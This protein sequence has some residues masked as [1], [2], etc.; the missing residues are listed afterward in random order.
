MVLSR[1][2]ATSGAW[3]RSMPCEA[4]TVCARQLPVDAEVTPDRVVLRAHLPGFTPEQ[5]EVRATQRAVVISTHRTAEESTPGQ[6][7][8]H[9]VYHGN[10]YRRL[11]LPWPVRPE[12]AVV[13]YDKGEL[14]ICL[15]RA[16]PARA[17][18]LTLPGAQVFER[19]EIPL[20]TSADVA[21]PSPGPHDTVF[22]P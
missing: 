7:V 3:L 22:R 2:R 11:R 14:T 18:L 8:S 9:E 12:G 13:T 6:L 1:D 17:I 19:P 10:W 21:P 15:P 16:T 20:R 5:I 4:E